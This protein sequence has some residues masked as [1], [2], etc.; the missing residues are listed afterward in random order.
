MIADIFIAAAMIMCM[1]MCAY[2]VIHLFNIKKYQDCFFFF[3][4]G[5]AVTYVGLLILG[6]IE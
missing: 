3:I 6:V 2:M 4:Q 5:A 1:L